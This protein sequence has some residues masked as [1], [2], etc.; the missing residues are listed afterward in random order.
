VA[1]VQARL[2]TNKPFLRERDGIYAFPVVVK[3]LAPLF[4]ISC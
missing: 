3:P 2:D 4:Q 1:G